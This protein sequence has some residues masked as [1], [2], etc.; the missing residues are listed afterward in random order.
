MWDLGKSTI[1]IYPHIM[2]VNGD[3]RLSCSKNTTMPSIAA[4]KTHKHQWM[5]FEWTRVFSTWVLSG[6]IHIHHSLHKFKYCIFKIAYLK[7]PQQSTA[8]T[9]VIPNV[10]DFYMSLKQLQYDTFEY[11]NKSYGLLLLI[12]WC[13]TLTAPGMEK[14]GMD[15]KNVCFCVPWK[16]EIRRLRTTWNIMCVIIF[17]LFVLT[18]CLKPLRHHQNSCRW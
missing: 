6:V 11:T 12:F 9:S 16:K 17:T 18:C 3:Q 8:L 14:N 5:S 13:L 15:I 2:K 4:I 10:I 1:P 7:V